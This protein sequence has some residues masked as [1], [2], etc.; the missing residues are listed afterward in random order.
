MFVVQA[1]TVRRI[2]EDH[3]N[4]LAA[5]IKMGAPDYTTAAQN[6]LLLASSA[7]QVEK[8]SAVAKI[9]PGKFSL[10]VPAHGVAAVRISLA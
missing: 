4:P 2:D 1:S 7:L 10:L 6:A 9:G 3:A 8:L 5:W